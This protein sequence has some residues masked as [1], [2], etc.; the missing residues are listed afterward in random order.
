MA[1]LAL[2]AAT[3]ET[4]SRLYGV[5]DRLE[6]WIDL[7]TLGTLRTR[8]VLHHGRRVIHEDLALDWSTHYLTLHREERHR[9]KIRDVAFDFG[10]SLQDLLPAFYALRAVPFEAGAERSF[11]VYASKKI[12]GFHL[13][14]EEAEPMSSPVFGPTR[15]FVLRPWVSLDATPFPGGRGRVWVREGADAVPLRLRGWIRTKD[16]FVIARLA[17]ELVRY[18]PPARAHRSLPPVL[19]PAPETVAG[20]P[21]WDPPPAV[22]AAREARGVRP[23][24]EK[25][26]VAVE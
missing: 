8:T 22:L 10:P 5:D 20:R 1:H 18:V 17:L 7:D 4:V 12:Y 25:R 2:H 26:S 3:S 9:G 21:V 6:A 16:G 24:D 11:A 23:R 15:A 19:P 13:A 14:V